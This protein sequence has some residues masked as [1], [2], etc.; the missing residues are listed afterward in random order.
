MPRAQNAH[1]FVNAGILLDVDHTTGKVKDAR[2]CFGGIDPDFVHASAIEE[3]LK[4]QIYYEKAVVQKIFTELPNV[5]HPNE[6]LPDPSP[7]Y[8]RK[9]ACGLLLKCLLDVAPAEKVKP[10]YKSGGPILK[11]DLSSGSQTF[12][13]Q[14]KNYPLTQPVNKIEGMFPSQ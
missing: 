10:E 5:L 11:R 12:E 2:I 13:S 9:L 7:D 14:K 1:A 4:G 8:R 3:L 6:V